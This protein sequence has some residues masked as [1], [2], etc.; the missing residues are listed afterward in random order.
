MSLSKEELKNLSRLFLSKEDSNT[1]L[2][3]SMMEGQPFSKELL[4]ELFA[5]YRLTEDED[6]KAR[7]KKEIEAIASPATISLFDSKRKLSRSG[8]YDPNE[9]TIAKNIDY[10]VYASKNELDGVKLARA[11]VEKYGHGYQYLLDNLSSDELVEFFATFKKGNTFSFAKKGISKIPKEIFLIPGIDE[12]EE[13]DMSGNKIGTVPASISKFTNLKKLMLNSNNLKKVN[14][15]ISKLEHLEYLDLSDNNFKEFP[16]EVCQCKGLKELKAMHMASYF[17]RVFVLPSA[18]A[19][20]KNLKTLHFHRS[21]KSI[22]KNL[23]DVLSQCTQLEILTLSSYEEKLDEIAALQK[24]LPNCK[25][26][27]SKTLS[28]LNYN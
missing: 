20:M 9:K 24:A 12:I 26:S 14:K 1:E 27:A 21:N 28:S 18:L 5:V 7:A 16:V 13:F 10:F 11:L 2:A 19:D 3:F 8:H 4:T 23:H 15:S 22:A 17:S 25:V 6:F